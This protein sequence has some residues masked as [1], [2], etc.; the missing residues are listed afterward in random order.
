MNLDR[1]QDIWSQLNP[2][3]KADQPCLYSWKKGRFQPVS[4]KDLNAQ[5]HCAAGYLM[6]K[7]LQPGQTVALLAAPSFSGIVMDLAVQLLGGVGLH[8]PQ[9][10]E[11]ADVTR[12]VREHK[13]QFIFVGDHENYL[14][15]GQLE[16]LKPDV[17]GLFLDTED[18]EGLSAEKLV[19]FDI[20]VM[21]G[22]A[23]WREEVQELNARKEAVE[24]DQV[25]GLFA[26][27]PKNRLQ[28]APV[29]FRRFLTHLKEAHERLAQETA[30]VVAT[31]TPDRYLQH[32]HG[33][34]APLSF[35]RGLYLLRPEEMDTQVALDAKP[36]WMVALPKDIELLYDRIPAHFLQKPDDKSLEKAQAILDIREAAEKEGKKAPFGKRIQY[37]TH[38][39]SLY[40]QVRKRL[41]G[42]LTH[43]LSDHDQPN[44]PTTRF[45]Q[46]CGLQ[47]DAMNLF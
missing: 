30:P 19:T 14:R 9:D 20:M 35:H 24:L 4:F 17:K 38:N 15:L 36:A 32:V 11:L 8:L 21:R 12:A 40:K 22:K 2:R 41:G 44:R 7:G 37:K 25:Y 5:A 27:N 46:E 47:V 28:F 13:A 29:R 31:L 16:T 1:I 10:L 45:F 18:A 26:H 39:Q 34:I 42:Q 43:L 6:S 33:S 23:V 3:G